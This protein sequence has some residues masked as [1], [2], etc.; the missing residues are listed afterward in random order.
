MVLLALF[1]VASAA[2]GGDDDA[3]SGG[4]AVS[5][6]A[7]PAD[8]GGAMGDA[9]AEPVVTRVIITN[10]SPSR[11]SNNVQKDL[12]PPS[13]MQLK[14]TYESLVGYDPDTAELDAAAGQVLVV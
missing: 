10:P 9:M 2:C 14:P 11:E 12:G 13:G 3:D 6:T 4:A 7:M 8:A 5:P 1:L